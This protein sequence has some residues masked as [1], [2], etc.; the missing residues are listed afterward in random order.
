MAIAPRPQDGAPAPALWRRALRNATLLATLVV[1]LALLLVARDLEAL[2]AVLAQLPLATLASLACHLPQI[3]F[4]AIAWQLLLPASHRPGLH[5]LS[6]LRWYREAADALLPAGS[7]LGQAAVMRLLA[8]GGTPGEEA[9]ASGTAAM[10]LES[11][12]QLA[13]ILLGFALLLIL[14]I[15]GGHGWVAAGVGLALFS[16]VAL[17]LL[18]HP[19]GL[20]LLRAGLAR[21]A[22][23]F[24]RL[25]PAWLDEAEAALRRIQGARGALALSAFL[26]LLA[27]GMGAIEVWLV[28]LLLGQPVSL[29][30]A[31][32]IES[33]AMTLR[34]LG[35]MLPGAAGVQEGAFVAAGALLGVPAAAALSLALV[36][37]AR[38]VLLVGLPGL[39]AW[40]RAELR[41]MR[42]DSKGAARSLA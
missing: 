11:V 17:G 36:R 27:W 10:L 26:N 33:V 12:S 23:R 22:R 5:R 24:P 9:A 16:V 34:N 1:V 8:R 37:R 7:L 30:E 14:G 3:L 19:L 15:D 29:A 39:L 32:V 13:F 35:F 25:D 18:L 20:R 28:L 21:L 38:E 42:Q 6:L 41:A 31:L 40:R 4:T 2:A